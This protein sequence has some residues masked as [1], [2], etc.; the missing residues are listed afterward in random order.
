MYE[1]E[2][3]LP[4]AARPPAPEPDYPFKDMAVG[5]SFFVPFETGDPVEWWMAWDTVRFQSQF[6]GSRLGMRF[7]IR[8]PDGGGLRVWRVS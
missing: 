8:R 5:D 6:Y 2:K 4:A 7:D 1:I 3:G